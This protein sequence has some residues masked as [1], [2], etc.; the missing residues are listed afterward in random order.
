MK[1]CGVW[2]AHRRL[3]SSVAITRPPASASLIVSTARAA[4]TTP[5]Q[6]HLRQLLDA[7]VD[8]LGG[9]ERPGRVVDQRPSSAPSVAASAFLTD[10]ERLVPPGVSDTSSAGAASRATASTASSQPGGTAI[11]TRSTVAAAVQRSQAPRRTAARPATSTN[12]F[13]VA[14]PRR[15][16]RRPP[17]GGRWPSAP[18]PDVLSGR[19]RPCRC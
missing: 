14:A 2:I 4:A 18:S 5:S 17:P 1:T 10:S 19:H 16:R 15:S 13:G 11:T 8:Q 3:R 6:P 9:D 7:A 12:A